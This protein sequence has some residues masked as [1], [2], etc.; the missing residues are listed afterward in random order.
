MAETDSV[1]TTEQEWDTPNPRLR[2]L[3]LCGLPAAA[4]LLKHSVVERNG[5]LHTE[6]VSSSDGWSEYEF[7]DED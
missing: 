2:R 5:V 7:I 4:T 6:D 1:A 3:R